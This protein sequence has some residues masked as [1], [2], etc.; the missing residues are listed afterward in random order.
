MSKVRPAVGWG[1]A[2]FLLTLGCAFLL[3]AA[4]ASSALSRSTPSHASAAGPSKAAIAAVMA[5][6]VEVITPSEHFVPAGKPVSASDGAGGALTAEIGQ[7]FP[8]ADGYG[9]L[10]FFWHDG[11]F[12]GWDSRYES[13]SIMRLRSA[14][15]RTFKVTYAHYAAN[16]PAYDP[17]LPPVTVSYRWRHQRLIASA[18]PPNR[19]FP[20]LEV[21]LLR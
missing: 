12:L 16:D 3:G 20:G 14:G 6:T 5:E 1:T 21:R 7:R 13:M 18:T 8:T 10:V 15:P 11:R 17:S 2:L 4:P 19:S 9:Q